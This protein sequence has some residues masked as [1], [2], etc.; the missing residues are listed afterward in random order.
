MSTQITIDFDEEARFVPHSI[1][2]VFETEEGDIVAN[3]VSIPLG[4][5]SIVTLVYLDAEGNPDPSA[6]A[7]KVIGAAGV[8]SD[9]ASTTVG[10][11][12]DGTFTATELP[13]ASVGAVTTLTFTDANGLTGTGTVTAIEAVSGGGGT[14]PFVPASIGVSFA[15]PTE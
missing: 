1:A 14:T 11:N 6:T 4:Q 13:T 12:G 3:E 7:V 15:A 2:V 8:S 10:D 5:K 9:T